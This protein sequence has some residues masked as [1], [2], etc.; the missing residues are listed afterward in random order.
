MSAELQTATQVTLPTGALDGHMLLILLIMLFAGLLGGVA[1]CF[2]ADREGAPTRIDW[3]KYPLLGVVAALTA[4]LFLNMLASTLLEGARTKPVDFFVFAG[5]CVIYVVASRRVFENL[6]QRM[7]EQVRRDVRQ[8]KQKRDELPL[9]APPPKQEPVLAKEVDAASKEAL[10]Y[11]DI[12][13]LRTL[14]D[15]SFVYGNLAAICE[16]TGLA[17]DLVSQRLTA[18]KSQGVIETRINDRN[19]LHWSVSLRGKTILDE[20]LNGQDDIKTA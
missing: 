11:N 2:L 6:I 12:E 3:I 15:Q 4:P 13:I 1:N 16:C 17:R 5:F 10:S 8:L 18:L 14:A 9:Q 19:V 20:V 7:L